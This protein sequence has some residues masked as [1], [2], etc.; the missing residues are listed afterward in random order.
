[1]TT[2]LD[3]ARLAG[4]SSATVSR[5][6]NGNA[7]VKADARDRVLAAAL[8]TG[9][10]PNRMAQSLRRGRSNTLALLVGDIE[11]NL[12]SSLTKHLQASVAEIGLDVLLYNL[13]HSPERLKSFLALAPALGL[14]GVVLATSDRIGP[15]FDPQ[16]AD[17]QARGLTLLSMIQRL[18]LRGVPSIVHEEFAATR[19]AVSYLL[20]TGRAPVMYVGRISTSDLGAERYRGYRAALAEAGEPL[21]RE[22]VQDVR[23]S[24]EAGYEAVTRALDAGLCFGSVQAGS[25]V[26]ALG[27]VAA[28]A[29]RGR[30]VPEDVAVIGFGNANWTAFTR[31]ALTTLS[32]HHEAAAMA[33]R[34]AFAAAEAGRDVPPLVTIARSL[35]RRRSA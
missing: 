14:R 9:Y 30:R 35:I 28:L 27:A 1:M 6:L 20:G 18:D 12:Y 33:A 29:D 24:Y 21:R 26:I 23:F 32:V 5:V 17:L 4:V 10:R 34:S 8:E 11:Q 15:E 31:P 22:L 7:G 25:D 3:I 19:E 16:L 2:V 13:D